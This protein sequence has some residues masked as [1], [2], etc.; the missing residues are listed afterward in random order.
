MNILDATCGFKGIWFQKNHPLV[1]FMDK[2]N[3]KQYHVTKNGKKK[4]TDI[5]P[6]IVSEWK[7]APFPDGYFDMIIFDPP[8]II[9]NVSSHLTL[10]YGNL[11]PSTWRQDLQIG[12]KKLFDILKYEGIFIFKWDECNKS[13]DEVLKL[14]PYQPLFG[15]RT[16][17]NNKNLWIV[18]LKYDVNDKLKIEG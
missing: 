12:I 1:V 13:I 10:D 4:C 11:N 5:K 16:G 14:F 8:H 3:G 7:D 18:F 9:Q 17:L 15:T 6:D 2:R